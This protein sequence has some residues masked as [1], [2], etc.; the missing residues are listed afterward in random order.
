MVKRRHSSQN[1]KQWHAIKNLKREIQKDIERKKFYSEFAAA[2]STV[3]S[4]VW[5]IFPLNAVP[6]GIADGQ[7]VGNEITSVNFNIKMF[8]QI[9]GGSDILRLNYYVVRFNSTA[10]LADT[11]AQL[12]AYL[13]QQSTVN[14]RSIIPFMTEQAMDEKLVEIVKSGHFTMFNNIVSQ[15]K[16]EFR[17]MYLSLKHRVEFSG[18]TGGSYTKGTVAILFLPYGSASMDFRCIYSFTD[19]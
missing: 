7:R 6:Q 17:E 10:H 4:G 14:E 1:T 16:F 19:A 9:P 11:A 12:A 8:C 18:A 5:Q 13:F 15:G 3:S 2:Q